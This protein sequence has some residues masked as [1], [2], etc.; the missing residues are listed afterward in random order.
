MWLRRGD[1]VALKENANY[2]GVVLSDP[3]PTEF[4]KDSAGHERWYSCNVLW[5]EPL[6]Q[7]YGAKGVECEMMVDHLVMIS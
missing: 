5:N 2:V 1:L 4:S 6:P 7:Y 3:V